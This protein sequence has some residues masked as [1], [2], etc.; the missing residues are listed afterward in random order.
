MTKQ[1]DIF[2]A[3][4]DPTRREILKML[5]EKPMTPNALAEHFNTTRQGVSHHIQIL[6]A[7]HVVRLGH[8]GKEINYII[9]PQKIK[10]IDEWLADFRT[11]W[12][13]RLDESAVVSDGK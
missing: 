10:E 13:N 5:I 7:C 1:R 3:I 12:E 8:W 6:A 2:H 4:A 11:L 9:S